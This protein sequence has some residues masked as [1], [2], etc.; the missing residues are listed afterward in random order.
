MTDLSLVQGPWSLQPA[1]ILRWFAA[2]VS[3]F[4]KT[5]LERFLVQM[6][7][8]IFRISE[9]PNAQDP[10]MGEPAPLRPVESFADLASLSLTAELQTLAHE[11]QELLQSKVGTTAYSTVHTAI[12]QKAATKRQD[13]KREIALQA[14]NDPAGEAKRKAQRSEQRAGQKKKRAAAFADGRGRLNSKKRRDE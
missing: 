1:S 2:V 3:H 4:D 13:R 8:P 7:T 11:V 10:Q 6:A 5:S 14:I 9:D 12:R